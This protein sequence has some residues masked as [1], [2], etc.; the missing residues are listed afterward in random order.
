MPVDDIPAT[1]NGLLRFNVSNAM[2]AAA[3]CLGAGHRHWR[4][5]GRAWRRFTIPS[6]RTRGATTS[7][8]GCR[9][10]CW[11]ISGTI[12]TVCAKSACGTQ[13]AREGPPNRASGTR[14]PPRTPLPGRRAALPKPS[15]RSCWV[16]SA[17]HSGRRRP[18][19]GSPRP[20][21]R[22]DDAFHE[23]PA[24]LDAGMHAGDVTTIPGD[25]QDSSDLIQA[26]LA[27]AH[28]GDPWWC[29]TATTTRFPSSS[30][31]ANRLRDVLAEAR[32]PAVGVGERRA[33]C[34]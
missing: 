17:V 3:L 13:V 27:Q 12:P 14:E 29:W 31:G 10:E 2:F 26:A 7:S 33:E 22:G 34:R 23:P 19:L 4:P 5:S 18:R 30:D 1:M 6:S 32:H 16:R 8:T 11:S 9:S 24:F 28:P 15:T 21:P 20:R 25:E